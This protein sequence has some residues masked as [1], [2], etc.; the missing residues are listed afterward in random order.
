MSQQISFGSCKNTYTTTTSACHQNPALLHSLDPVVVNAE[1]NKS[2]INFGNEEREFQTTSLAAKPFEPARKDSK[3]QVQQDFSESTIKQTIFPS[4]SSKAD[5]RT[6]NL[7]SNQYIPPFEQRI[8]SRRN[9]FEDYKK[10]SK[11]K[12]KK[13]EK[14]SAPCFQSHSISL[15]NAEKENETSWESTAQSSYT[16]Q[17]FDLM[18]KSKSS[19]HGNNETQWSLGSSRPQYSTTA[20]SNDSFIHTCTIAERPTSSKLGNSSNISLGTEEAT[21]FVTSNLA[22][23]HYKAFQCESSYKH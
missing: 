12:N 7:M 14:V 15:G 5:F 8:H 21:N 2:S 3:A 22:S 23:K 18:G 19:S 20:K 13:K 16:P 10:N 9:F 4:K 1:A 17:T 6:S 11:T